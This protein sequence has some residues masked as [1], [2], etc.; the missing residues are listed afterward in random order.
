MDPLQQPTQNSNQPTSTPTENGEKKIGPIVGIV[1]IIV[2]LLIAAIYFWAR[3]LNDR[4]G[5]NTNDNQVE[6]VNQ[7]APSKTDAEAR[8][9]SEV[10]TDGLDSLDDLEF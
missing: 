7:G 8:I 9:D 3:T 4:A 5:E 2:L 6:T 1:I 10:G